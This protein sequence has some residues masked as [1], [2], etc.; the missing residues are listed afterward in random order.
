MMLQVPSYEDFEALRKEVAELR[1]ELEFMKQTELTWLTLDQV[2]AALKVSKMTVYRLT[3]RG[4]LQPRY[5]GCKPFYDIQQVRVYIQSTRVSAEAA[6][7][8]IQS[9]LRR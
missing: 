6:D 5:E 7:G 1:R 8:R 2:A 4:K 9:A 3:K